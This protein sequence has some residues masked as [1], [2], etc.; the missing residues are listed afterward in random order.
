MRLDRRRFLLSAGLGIVAL[1]V[2]RA[3]AAEEVHYRLVMREGEAQLLPD[4]PAT[5]IWSYDGQVPGPL[6]TAPQGSVLVVEAENRLAVPTTVHWHGLRLPNAMD[7]VAG[8]TQP[9]IEPGSTSYS[10]R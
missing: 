7:G 6:L 9:P 2:P 5:K 10:M 8:L 3:R 1:G 4:G